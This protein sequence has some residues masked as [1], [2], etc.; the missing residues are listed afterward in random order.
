MQ[1]MH[2]P[3]LALRLPNHSDNASEAAAGSILYIRYAVGIVDVDKCE[4]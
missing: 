4:P 2:I 1:H 3:A